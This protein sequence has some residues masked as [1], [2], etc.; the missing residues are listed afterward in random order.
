MIFIVIPV[1]N[2]WEFTKDCLDS[3]FVQS[4]KEYKVIV[5][6]HG[7]TDDT[8][9]NIKKFYDWVILLKGDSSLWWSGAVNLGVRYALERGANYILT[10]NN[11]LTVEKDYIKTMIDCAELDDKVL[12]GSVSLNIDSREQ[13]AFAGVKWSRFTARYSPAVLLKLPYS[14]LKKSHQTISTDLLPGRGT[15]IPTSVFHRIGLFD[16]HLFPHYGADED[17][18]L[19]ARKAG[20]AL[21]V[22]VAAVV[23]SHVNE[24]G[25]KSGT[26]NKSNIIQSLTSIRSPLKL[27]TRWAWARRH[28]HIPLLYFILDLTRITKSLIYRRKRFGKTNG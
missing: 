27:K 20:Y 18:S 13:V 5:V 26:N 17:F 25:L 28:G 6:D 3:L 4:Y 11:D 16:D 15:L 10:L 1:Y 2:R 24:T 9:D 8:T 21:K 22:N 7:S 12:V 19:R 14:E 23:Y